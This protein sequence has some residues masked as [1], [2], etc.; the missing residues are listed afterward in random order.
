MKPV[1]SAISNDEALMEEKDG[2]IAGMLLCSKKEKEL[3]FLAVH[4]EYRKKG[5]AKRLIKKMTEWFTE[6]I[7]VKTKKWLDDC[8]T[9]IWRNSWFYIGAVKK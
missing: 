2:S 3:S 8:V 5:V 6:S 1:N 9:I 4:P 7:F